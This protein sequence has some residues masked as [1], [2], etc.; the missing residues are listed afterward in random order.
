MEVGKHFRDV[1][2]RERQTILADLTAHLDETNVA[3][4]TWEVRTEHVGRPD[5]YALQLRKDLG[6]G[7][8]LDSLERA[9]RFNARHIRPRTKVLVAFTV[10][11]ISAA[12]GALSRIANYQPL[13][14]GNRTT[15]CGV[16]LRAGNASEEQ[17]TWVQGGEFYV[18]TWITNTGSFALRVTDIAAPADA[19]ISNDSWPWDNWRITLSTDEQMPIPR[20][21]DRP[22]L[23]FMLAS[24]AHQLMFIRRDF[25]TCRSQFMAGTSIGL[26]SVN[27]KFE[28]G[29]IDRAEQLDL[30]FAYSVVEVDC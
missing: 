11:L 29:G 16:H 2:W 13:T 19:A 25:D 12:I 6:V 27:V 9:R 15:C 8:T 14:F 28:I 30:G 22:F 23:P 3:E 24:G 17:F 5:E 1:S 26:N 10:L 20:G 7:T 18:G 21:H 4:N